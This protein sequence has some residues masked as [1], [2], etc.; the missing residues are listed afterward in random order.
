MLDWVGFT[1]CFYKF[2]PVAS[3]V[4]VVV[5]VVVVDDDDDD[6]FCSTSEVLGC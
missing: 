2:I 5:V 6:V 3:V 1:S 4:V